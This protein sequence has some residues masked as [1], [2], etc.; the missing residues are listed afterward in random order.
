[1]EGRLGQ[2]T[3]SA[4]SQVQNLAANPADLAAVIAKIYGNQQTGM[5]D[6]GMQ[7]GQNWMNN[8]GQLTEMLKN[9]GTYQNQAFDYNQNQ[10]YQAAKAA[11]SALREGAFRNL[12]S[13]GTNIASGISG[14]ANM[15]FQQEQM[16]EFIKRVYGK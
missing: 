9:F 5:Q 4:I 2:N 16:D 7:A 6:I 3:S 10:P 1:M 12:S 15:Q 11:E 14:K 8:Q 13:A